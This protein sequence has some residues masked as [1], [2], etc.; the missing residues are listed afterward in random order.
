MSGAT[1]ATAALV[2]TMIASTAYQAYQGNRADQQQR[3]AQRQAQRQAEAT[4]Q[5]ADEANNKVNQK[6]PDV[7][8]AL[9]S[10]MQAG[11][12]G[13]SGTMLTGPGGVDP[14]ALSLGKSTLLGG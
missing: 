1:T 14:G 9:A 3:S 12:S 7:A 6:R 5:A 11:K 13:A 2:G 10:A 4:A 8:G